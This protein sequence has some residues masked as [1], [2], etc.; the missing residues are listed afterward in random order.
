MNT[1][2]IYLALSVM[3]CDQTAFADEDSVQA[4]LDGA[5]SVKAGD[6]SEPVDVAGAND[7]RS[8]F[9]AHHYQNQEMLDAMVA[10]KRIIPVKKP[11]NSDD[12]GWFPAR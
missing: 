8:P 11:Y 1:L 7:Y 5:K 9:E 4:M 6:T 3:V 12:E 2:F 10:P